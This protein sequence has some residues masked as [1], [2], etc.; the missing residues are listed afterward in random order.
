MTE[1]YRYDAFG[2][3]AGVQSVIAEGVFAEAET[4]LS[5]FLYAGEQY[6]NVTRLYYLRARQYDTEIGRFTQEDTYL[7][8]GR[9]C[10][11]M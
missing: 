3:L 11:H 6:D 4:A 10:L 5:R 1:T 9:N 8:D 7:C 2:T